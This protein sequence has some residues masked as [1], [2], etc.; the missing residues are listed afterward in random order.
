LRSVERLDLAL[1]VDTEH[2]RAIRRVHVEAD[3]IGDLLLELR[4]VGDL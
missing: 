4:V 1:L 2:Q 3:D